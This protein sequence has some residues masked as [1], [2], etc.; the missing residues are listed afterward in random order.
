[1]PPR[2]G[3]FA[4]LEFAPSTVYDPLK[5]LQPIGEVGAAPFVIVV[6]NDLEVTTLRDFIALARAK[7]KSINY[8][9]AGTG[10]MT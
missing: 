3:A 7:S 4:K 5:D 2:D 1:M 8:S 10:G 9:S 6:S